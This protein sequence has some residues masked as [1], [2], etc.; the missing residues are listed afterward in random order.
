M[1]TK[2]EGP[3]EEWKTSVHQACRSIAPNWPLDRM[4]AVNPWWSLIKEP[5]QDVSA[6]LAT[7]GGVRMLMPMPHYAK[8]WHGNLHE[9]HL[10]NSRR[11]SGSDL[12]RDQLIT[13]LRQ[14]FSIDVW[15]SVADLMDQN[16]DRQHRMSWMDEIIFQISQTCGA[17]FQKGGQLEEEGGNRSGL[18]S[19]WLSSLQMDRG[20]EVLMGEPGLRDQFLKLPSDHFQLIKMALD[21]FKV[22]QELVQDL[23]H[24][25]LL[26][27]GGWAS[28]VAYLEFTESQNG[29]EVH[30]IEELLAIRIA[31][32]L[33]LWRHT[34][35]S[36]F[37]GQFLERLWS[38]QLSKLP[39]EIARQKKLQEAAWVWQNANEQAYQ[40]QL[41]TL[42][43]QPPAYNPKPKM[44]A[45]FCIDVRSEP[46]RRALESQ[47]PGIQTFGFAGF[48][49]LP[50]DYQ[51]LA[52]NLS[53]PQCP[54]PFKPAIVAQ[55]QSLD[56]QSSNSVSEKLRKKTHWKS[57]LSSAPSMF[58]MVE[59][60]GL[61]MAWKLLKD[62]FGSEKDH[63][64][65]D[66][67]HGS[68]SRWN[69]S[70]DGKSLSASEK[71]ELGRAI[72][73]NMGL[74]N[75]PIAPSVLLVGHG[76]GVRN[77]PQAAGLA[78]GACG[79]Q[80][81]AVN[82]RVLAEILNDSEVRRLM[83]ESGVNIPE[84]TMFIPALHDTATDDIELLGVQP[85][86][87]KLSDWLKQASQLT[88]L[89]RA[90]KLELG[91]LEGE[92]LDRRLRQQARD[93][94]QVRPEWG[95]AN[96]AAF[97]VAPRTRTANVNLKG[98]SFLHEYQWQKDEG[99]KTLEL[100]LTGPMVVT[101]WI[102]MQYNASVSDPQRYGSGNKLL[103]N[104]VGG[105]LGVFEGNGGDLRTGLAMQSVHNGRQWMHQL[106]RLSVVVAAPREAIQEVYDRHEVVKDLVDHGW[107][108]LFRLDDD[109]RVVERFHDGDWQIEEQVSSI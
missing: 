89:E 80:S 81:G 12:S 48:F 106:L 45:A 36:G 18:Y 5:I 4:I 83:V 85:T 28:W 26:E 79:G 105:N 8:Q 104:V 7:L 102:N 10:Q 99:F 55:E 34:Q 1:E 58:S 3:A 69:L 95:L 78:C 67:I 27:I 39:A 30:L 46:Y 49:G 59:A 92:E 15:P 50:I 14:E 100:I 47:D 29:H 37:M 25:W 23:C 6:R 62:V 60:A 82:V 56:R 84:Q 32:D 87:E 75:G 38:E 66:H 109:H 24:G 13:Q 42:L 54:G 19:L 44:Q 21:V 22:P 70:Q 40:D 71:A 31:W 41:F 52:G 86:D 90:P 68:G 91:G 97:V 33:A 43:R 107:I 94:L 11:L 2:D 63:H 77:N 57:V 35:D 103:H 61:S 51:P 76:S 64:P 72:L 20:I 96:N 98:R 53:R 16:R 93:S 108:H 9:G 73:K 74:L 65:V 17:V 88:R 101:H